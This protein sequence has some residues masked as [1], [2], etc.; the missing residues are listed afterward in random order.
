MRLPHFFFQVGDDG[1][2]HLIFQFSGHTGEADDTPLLRLD[3]ETGGRADRIFD[4]NGSFG[5]P[6]LAFVILSH[7]AAKFSEAGRNLFFQLLAVDQLTTGRCR[8]R[9]PG[10][11]IDRRPQSPRDNDK[12][13]PPQRNSEHL[14]NPLLVVPDGSLVMHIQPNLTQH[15]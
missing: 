9:L 6:G 1:V 8:R 3:D 4:R 14:D 11:I 12:I 10:H 2:F 15:L 13:N 5:Y 7:L